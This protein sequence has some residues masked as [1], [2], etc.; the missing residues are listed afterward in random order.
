MS[1]LSPRHPGFF[2]VMASRRA[3]LTLLYLML[4]LATGIFAFTFT[5]TGLSLG[6]GLAIL[7][8]GIPVLVTFLIGTRLLSV[9]ELHLL[10]VLVGD[11]GVEPPAL[12]PLG[13]CFD[14]FITHQDLQQVQL[15][16]GQ[17]AGADQESHQ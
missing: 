6:L 17:Q 3:Y 11:G 2:E 4:S 9:A 10:K 12:L 14:A 15:G 1:L 5:V 8:I 7:I 16:H 13:G